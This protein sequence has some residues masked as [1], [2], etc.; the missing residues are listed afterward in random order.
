MRARDIASLMLAAQ[1][2]RAG[3]LL[4]QRQIATS[5]PG[6]IGP[7]VRALVDA[8]AAAADVHELELRGALATLKAA[9]D[10]AMATEPEPA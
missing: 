5:K 9:N 8:H 2:N 7:M 3:I 10:E 6:E 4:A 1:A